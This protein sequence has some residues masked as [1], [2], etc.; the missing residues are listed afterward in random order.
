MLVADPC[1]H[2]ITLVAVG[3]GKCADNPGYVVDVSVA[4]PEPWRCLRMIANLSTRSAIHLSQLNQ[5][6]SQS[7]TRR[8]SRGTRTRKKGRRWTRRCRPKGGPL[9]WSRGRWA[10][11]RQRLLQSSPLRWTRWKSTQGTA[12]QA[13]QKGQSS[14][15][16]LHVRSSVGSALTRG[17]VVPLARQLDHLAWVAE[18]AE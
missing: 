6:S 12:S 17:S 15:A 2:S 3:D 5:R 9:R 4:L 10:F 16:M 11:A 8:P 1:A 14:T 7:C 18:R 13:R